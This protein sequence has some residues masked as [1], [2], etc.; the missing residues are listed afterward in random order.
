LLELGNRSEVKN[1]KHIFQLCVEQLICFG[2]LRQYPGYGLYVKLQFPGEDTFSESRALKIT[3]DITPVE[4]RTTHAVTVGR[5]T[6]LSDHFPETAFGITIILCNNA[7]IP[8]TVVARAVLPTEELLQVSGSSVRVLCLYSENSI[9]G[10]VR[11]SISYS[12][13]TTAEDVSTVQ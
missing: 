9:V 7:E 3:S 10:K 6:E 12:T 1:A 8:E 11:L 2:T 4:L 5:D 13:E